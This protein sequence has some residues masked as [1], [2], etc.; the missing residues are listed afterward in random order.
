MCSTLMPEISGLALSFTKYSSIMW[1][2]VNRHRAWELTSRGGTRFRRHTFFSS[3]HD[4]TTRLRVKAR[5]KPHSKA[6]ISSLYCSPLTLLSFCRPFP[7][8]QPA[9]SIATP[10]RAI[11]LRCHLKGIRLPTIDCSSSTRQSSFT[12]PDSPKLAHRTALSSNAGSGLYGSSWTQLDEL[13]TF[14]SQMDNI[15]KPLVF[16][17]ALLACG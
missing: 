11:I 7:P 5:V 9:T 3:Y 15:G 6:W 1:K 16:I 2:I 14:P 4:R 17:V 10:E 12:T 8:K 13:S